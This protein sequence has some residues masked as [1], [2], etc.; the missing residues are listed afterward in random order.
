MTTF[1]R[2]LPSLVHLLP[3]VLA[4]LSCAPASD[5]STDVEMVGEPAFSTTLP[6]GGWV[7]SAIGSNGVTGKASYDSVAKTFRTEGAGSVI[8]GTADNFLFLNRPHSGEGEIT[9]R[10]TG[11]SGANDSAR[12]GV[13][14]RANN[15]AKDAP[16]MLVYQNRQGILGFTYRRAAG[17]ATQ[18]TFDVASNKYQWMKL[19]RRGYEITAYQSADGSDWRMI[20]GPYYFDGL[21]TEVRYGIAVANYDTTKLGKSYVDNVRVHKLPQPWSYQDIG[22]VITAGTAYYSYDEQVFRVRGGGG[23]VHKDQ[24]GFQ[25]TNRTMYGCHNELIAHL[26]SVTGPAGSAGGLMLRASL[27]ADAPYL[28]VYPEGSGA[29]F[30]SRTTAGGSVTQRAVALP[31][32]WVKIAKTSSTTVYAYVSSDGVTWQEAGRLTGGSY[33][34]GC[35]KSYLGLFSRSGTSG[36]TADALFDQVTVKPFYPQ[37]PNLVPGLTLLPP[38]KR[39]F[40]T[41]DASVTAGC[42]TSGTHWVLP[43]QTAAYNDGPTAVVLGNPA[44]RS[45]VFKTTSPQGAKEMSAFNQLVLANQQGQVLATRTSGFSLWDAALR[46]EHPSVPSQGFVSSTN[47]GLSPGWG[48]VYPSTYAC[49]FFLLDNVADGPLTVTYT[50]NVSRYVAEDVNSDAFTDN[51]TREYATLQ[52]CTSGQTR[53]QGADKQV[54]SSSGIWQLSQTC[55]SG[56]GQVCSGNSSCQAMQPHY[57]VRNVDVDQLGFCEVLTAHGYACDGDPTGVA[58]SPDAAGPYLYIFDKNAMGSYSKARDR[59][60]VCDW[61]DETPESERVWHTGG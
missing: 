31:G 30:S 39:T 58:C 10:A 53:C 40:S 45:D 16:F 54:C 50:T 20:N 22:T 25:F 23:G 57:C 42:V 56:C 36:L 46:P 60:Y 29:Y 32:P 5:P 2:R 41:T 55:A 34:G 37:G 43:Y 19:V 6:S 52:K 38:Q 8:G 24:S 1:A 21:G 33:F 27:A 3:I 47:Q 11:F 61:N 49:Q 14:I 28:L 18:G 4:S 26:A 48:A 7:V 13:M 51:T 35:G 59:Y 9:I 12:H 44:D 17:Q 15:T